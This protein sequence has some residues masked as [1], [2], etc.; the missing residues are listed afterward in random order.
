MVQRDQMQ[1]WLPGIQLDSHFSPPVL[2]VNTAQSSFS[3]LFHQGATKCSYH[4][5]NG[6]KNSHCWSHYDKLQALV[7]FSSYIIF[8]IGLSALF[9]LLEL[10][11]I[12][13]YLIYS[14]SGI[15]IMSDVN[16]F[17]I[18]SFFYFYSN[19]LILLHYNIMLGTHTEE[20]SM[21]LNQSNVN[22]SNNVYFNENMVNHV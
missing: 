17:L 15:Q 7:I 19:G 1:I 3:L 12:I 14:H 4:L 21:D 13:M 22:F 16:V 9:T 20:N 10:V 11:S 2:H 6:R 5:Q 8:K 18:Y